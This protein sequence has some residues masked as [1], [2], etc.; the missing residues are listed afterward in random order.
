[1]RIFALGFCGSFTTLSALVM[2]LY[3]MLQ[4]NEIFNSLRWKAIWPSTSMCCTIRAIRWPSGSSDG[5]ILE[6]NQVTAYFNYANRT[7]LGLG[8]NTDSDI[9]GLSPGDSADSTNWQHQ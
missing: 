5:E 9:L 1:M 4:R 8:V 6:I 3:T 7:V 2:E